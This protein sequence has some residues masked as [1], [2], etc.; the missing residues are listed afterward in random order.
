M[1]VRYRGAAASITVGSMPVFCYTGPTEDSQDIVLASLEVKGDYREL[2]VASGRVFGGANVGVSDKKLFPI[3]ITKT[4]TGLRLST[5]EPLPSG[6]YIIL[7]AGGT[8]GYDFGVS[9]SEQ[10]NPGKD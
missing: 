2:Q 4:S 6:Q 9:D 8:S 1:K 3:E 7:P 5:K 10:A